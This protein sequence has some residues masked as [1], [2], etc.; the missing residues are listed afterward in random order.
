[1]IGHGDLEGPYTEVDDLKI[2]RD[3]RFPIRVT[4]QFYQAT[5]VATLDENT[6]VDLKKQLDSVFKGADAVG[7][8]VTEGTTLRPT[9]H[10]VKC[11]YPR[12]WTEPVWPLTLANG[13]SV[14][15]AQAEDFLKQQGSRT[16]VL[17]RRY[18]RWY[19]CGVMNYPQPDP[20]V[21]ALEMAKTGDFAVKAEKTE[22]KKD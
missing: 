22:D 18:P 17:P 8:L 21:Y 6:V 14:T 15:R 13:E 19:W 7:S 3:H 11:E 5:D 10:N 4:V 12:W 9:E 20:F 1:V 2:E 16:A